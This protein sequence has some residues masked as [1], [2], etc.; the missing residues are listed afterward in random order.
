M[1]KNNLSDVIPQLKTLSEKINEIAQNDG[2]FTT[3]VPSLSVHKR[4]APTTPVH[5]IY[6]I[7][8]GVI[9]Q[10]SKE[11]SLGGKS[12]H[13]SAGQTLLTMLEL[14][15]VSHVT[16]ASISTP[17]LGMM[18]T[19]EPG[20]VMQAAAMLPSRSP[21]LGRNFDPL[22]VSELNTFLADALIRLIALTEEPALIPHLAP[23]IQQ[24]I[25]IRL[26]T[27]SYGS[28]LRHIA[29]PGSSGQQIS[30]VVAWLKQH[31]SQPIC[32]DELAVKAAMSPSSFRQHFRIATGMSPLQF[33]KKLRLQ[34][35]R[36]QM[37]NNNLNAVTA[38]VKVG[39]ESASQFSR[40]Y[41]REFGESPKK[42]IRHQRLPPTIT[43]TTRAGTT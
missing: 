17:F 32:I 28:A 31:F 8:L 23:L 29:T 12:T 21:L 16:A 14:P 41:R 11:L 26:L 3:S 2:D 27:G 36:Q 5:C 40:E 19:M 15:V 38:A 24:E 1:Q 10:G 7:G 30:S 34:E 33:I 22:A 42:D 13:Y 37:L 6:G 18:I 4:S 43:E 25:I 9:I 35:A 20:A 39:Y